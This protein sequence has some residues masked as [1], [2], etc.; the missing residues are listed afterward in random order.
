MRIL[1]VGAGPAGLMAA[2][3]AA[4]AGAHVTVIDRMPSPARKLLMAG[5]GGLNLTHSEP[6][7]AF[8]ARYGSAARLAHAL[9]PSVYTAG[10]AGLG[11][12]SRR[13]D[14][15][16]QQR[17]RFSKSDEGFAAAARLA[18]TAGCTGRASSASDVGWIG[19]AADGRVQFVDA[20]G[21]NMTLASDAMILALGGASWPRLGS[22][23]GWRDV[24]AREGIVI[25]PLAPSNA[26]VRI[27]W[28]ESVRDRFAG[29]PLKR[30]SASVNGH[31]VRGEA[32]LTRSGL[33]GGV[34]YAL[35]GALRAGLASGPVTIMLDL[36]P[37][38]DIDALSR[39]IAT[40]RKGDSLSNILRK[41]AGLA[42]QAIALLR[43]SGTLGREPHELAWRI[44]SVALTVTAFEGLER[45]IS[46]AGGVVL[47]EVDASL[48]LHRKPGVFVA[49]EMLDWDAPT[50]GY[51]L[52]ACM[53]TGQAA[54]QGAVQWI[55]RN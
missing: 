21:M 36:R 50:G 7:E 54:G 16:R 15:H 2:E 47:D 45:A 1:V 5:R 18:R 29:A 52:Q 11:R 13:R 46:T 17:A 9:C 25:A 51:L 10:V 41:A 26:G 23:G 34:V 31:Q 33:E 48:M 20:A 24:L 43:D 37:D 4:A 39:R 38:L 40:A 42:P 30:I 12:R 53:A 32:M 44:K 14:F 3:R 19:W 22:D 6:W 55:A 27:V 35:G 8:L 28:S 49:G